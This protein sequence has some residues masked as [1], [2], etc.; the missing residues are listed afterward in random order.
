MEV[1]AGTLYLRSAGQACATRHT[2]LGLTLQKQNL[3]L[4]LA[5]F[6][7]YICLIRALRKVSVQMPKEMAKTIHEE[8]LIIL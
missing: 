6:P 2:D 3:G 4:L 1:A 5:A 7:S 8:L